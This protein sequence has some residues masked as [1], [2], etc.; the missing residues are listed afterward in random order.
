VYPKVGDDWMVYPQARDNMMLYPQAQDAPITYP[1]YIANVDVMPAIVDEED[2]FDYL[3]SV[4]SNIPKYKLGKHRIQVEK[5]KDLPSA[6]G[7]QEWYFAYGPKKG[8]FTA[9]KYF[10]VDKNG[11]IFEYNAKKNLWSPLVLAVKK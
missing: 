7:A 11:V 6:S 4:L 5:H 9:S 1:D 3:F 2:A 10:A 8:K